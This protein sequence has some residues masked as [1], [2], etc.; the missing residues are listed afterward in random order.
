MGVKDRPE[1]MAL[2]HRGLTG[3]AWRT[4]DATRRKHLLS[5]AVAATEA[6]HWLCAIDEQLEKGSTDYKSRRNHDTD[7]SV[8]LGLR[9][10][11]DRAMH[12]VVICTAE[13][14]RSFFNPPPG[15]LFYI[16]SSYPIWTPVEMLPLAEE[17]HRN[18]KREKA[19]AVQVAESVAHKPIFRALKFLTREL[20]SKIT[21]V[22]TDQPSWF[23]ELSDKE[24]LAISE[25]PMLRL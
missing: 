12:Q 1:A 23:R 25:S 8:L 17:R 18:E 11:R 16:A 10:V 4:L 3:A 21:L 20:T 24:K 9:H 7:G 15:G 13:D 14:V 5:C 22:S 2:A 6:L 19:Y